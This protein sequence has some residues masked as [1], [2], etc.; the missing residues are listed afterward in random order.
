MFHG[1][2]LRHELF[3][4]RSGE[5]GE[6]LQGANG[7]GSSGQ[8]STGRPA[9]RFERNYAR[10]DGDHRDFALAESR[11]RP[12]ILATHSHRVIIISLFA[13]NLNLP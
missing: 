3:A 9:F 12:C 4:E 10:G 1:G 8:S 7:A 6:L 5:S 2:V 13:S 11:R